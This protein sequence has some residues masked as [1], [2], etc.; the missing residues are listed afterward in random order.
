ML[1]FGLSLRAQIPL[2][3]DNFISDPYGSFLYWGPPRRP[4]YHPLCHPLWPYTRPAAVRDSPKVGL[5]FILCDSRFIRLI[6]NCP[7]LMP[8][9]HALIPNSSTLIP[10]SPSLITDSLSLIFWQ[11]AVQCTLIVVHACV[12]IMVHACTMITVHACTM[13]IS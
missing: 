11:S 12:M 1:T 5:Q 7:A 10:D 6:P 9:S 2:R 8:D 4:L 3:F 13:I